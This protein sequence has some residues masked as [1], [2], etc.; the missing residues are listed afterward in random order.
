MKKTERINTLMRFMNNRGHFTVAEVMA[1]FQISRSTA[2]RDIREIE[3]LGLPLV[4]EVGRDGGYSVLHNAMLPAIRF[5]DDEIKALFISFMASRNQQL[6]FLKSRQSLAEKIMGLLSESQQD[7][8]LM[9]NETL[10]F[11]GTNPHNPDLLELSDIPDP[12][13]EQ[14]IQSLLQNRYLSLNRTDLPDL[15]IYLKS[16]YKDNQTWWLACIDLADF[17]TK[18]IPFSTVANVEILKNAETYQTKKVLH[19]ARQQRQQNTVLHLGSKAIA[20]YHKYHPFEMKLAYLDPYQMTGEI[21]CWLAFEA[22][23]QLEETVNWLRFLG[24]ELSIIQAPE[25]LLKALTNEKE[26]GNK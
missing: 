20:Q 19:K 5:T 23:E 14:L 21:R 3:R 7:D 2:V 16:L 9:L 4:A 11:Q 26:C 8:L 1:E 13:L 17:Q 6:P 15:D 12:L 25:R 18:A 10:L 22:D 24:K